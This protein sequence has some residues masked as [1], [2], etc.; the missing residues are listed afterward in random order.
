MILK[1]RQKDILLK[2]VQ[3]YV[4]L[5]Q[6]ISSKFLKEKHKLPFSPATIRSEMQK[7]T[8]EGFLFQPHTSAGRIPTDRGYRVFVDEVLKKEP[9]EIQVKNYSKEKF[10]DEFCFLRSLLADL[11]RL[12]NVFVSVYVEKKKWYV[13]E[14][15]KE[16]LKEPE[17]Q[18]R[19][20]LFQFTLFVKKIEKII[21]KW[22]INSE[23][24]VW[25]GREM[26]FREGK[27][28]SLIS[29]KISLPELGG[30][31]VSFSGPQRMDYNKN[32]GIL[33]SLKNQLNN[34]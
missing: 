7:L 8:Q 29:C 6:P 19:D 18:E 5:A 15:W 2:I 30:M 27:K 12:S 17:F 26:P 28:F 23:I 34:L 20:F 25:I 13:E 9:K 22:K 24:K 32:I 14:G 4:S 16:I 33:K 10:K 3:D 21:Q 11:S 31:R 1:E